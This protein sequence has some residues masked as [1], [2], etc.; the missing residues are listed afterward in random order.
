MDEN[1]KA[2]LKDKRT[3]IRRA[4]SALRKLENARLELEALGEITDWELEFISSVSK[5]LD[6]YDAAFANPEL[7]GRLE[8]LSGRQKQVLSAMRKK[9]RDHKKDKAKQAPSKLQSYQSE[10]KLASHSDDK[11]KQTARPKCLDN[12][13]KP[14]KK[15]RFHIID[16]GKK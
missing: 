7:G 2:R 13:T 16:G 3:K 12:N 6:L 14:S 1:E 11:I 5:R 10:D 8:A 15:P 9:I 4:R